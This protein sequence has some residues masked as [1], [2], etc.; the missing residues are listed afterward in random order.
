MASQFALPHRGMNKRRIAIVAG[1]ILLLLAGL[2]ALRLGMPSPVAPADPIEAQGRRF[3]ELALAFGQ[4]NEKEVDAYF[5]PDSLRPKADAKAPSLDDLQ[6]DLGQLAKDIASDPGPATP[7]RAR[8]ES[9]IEHLRALI[10]TIQN[11]HSLSFD[12]EAKRVFG[13]DPVPVDQAKM[14]RAVVELGR[15]LPGPGPLAARVDAFR[16]RYVIPEDRREALFD[17]ALGECRRRTRAHWM[18]P[19]TERVD[20]EWTSSVDAAWHRY[21]GHYHSQLQINPQAVAFLGSALDVACHEAYPGHHAQFVM[22]AVAA[23]PAGLPI[24]ERVVLLRSPDSLFRE[25]AANYGVDLAFPP[26][27]RLAFER[28]VLF[29][30]AGFKPAEAAKF[31]KVRA[32]IDVLAPATVPILRDYRD[33]KLSPDAA[34][35]ALERDAL[36]SSPQALLGFVDQFGPYALGYT[37][38]RDW[39]ADRVAAAAGPGG[40]RWAVLK[41]YV[42]APGMP[43]ALTPAT[44]DLP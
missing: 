29:P 23:R 14:T 11:P 16:A 19:S 20:V 21:N 4:S 39:V 2:A 28:D 25:G 36:V 44:K 10:G 42:A 3:V 8:L 43:P 9:R 34:A 40:D 27:D 26:A 37:I 13:I 17:R 1:V 33:G 7:H 41:T 35:V 18:L 5:G 38:A 12:E 22:Q 30:L 31:E 15:L 6:R 32:L 24:E